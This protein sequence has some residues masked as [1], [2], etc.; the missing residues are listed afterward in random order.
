MISR[1]ILQLL[2]NLLSPVCE[3]VELKTFKCQL[4]DKNPLVIECYLKNDYFPVELD[5]DFKPP[6][7]L[8]KLVVEHVE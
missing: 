3:S 4:F 7:I 1:L 2:F 8:C 5:L 6:I